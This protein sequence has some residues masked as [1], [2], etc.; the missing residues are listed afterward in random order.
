MTVGIAAGALYVQSLKK[1]EGEKMQAEEKKLAP[2]KSMLKAEKEE[3][4]IDD[5]P[6]PLQ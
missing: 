4:K 5:F 1:G 6:L 2:E 3:E